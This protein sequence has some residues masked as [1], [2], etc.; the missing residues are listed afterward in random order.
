MAKHAQCFTC[1]AQQKLHGKPRDQIPLLFERGWRYVIVRGLKWLQCASCA[2][3]Q[4][5]SRT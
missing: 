1:G 5:R 3:G 2:S 4:S